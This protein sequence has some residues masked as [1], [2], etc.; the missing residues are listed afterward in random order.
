M[1]PGGNRI[2]KCHSFGRQYAFIGV[3]G[4]MRV[5]VVTTTVTFKSL[6]GDEI[7][8][9]LESGEGQGKA[10]GYAI[11]G[12]AASF[13]RFISGSYSNVVGLPLFEVTQLLSGLGFRCPTLT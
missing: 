3:R 2:P 10:G 4:T 11:Q 8:S 1:P 7:E 13:V 6:T 5:R 12:R 9:Y